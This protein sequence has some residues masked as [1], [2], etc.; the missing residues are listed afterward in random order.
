[1]YQEALNNGSSISLLYL[2]M[3]AI[4]PAQIGKSTFLKRLKGQMKWDL[5]A[6]V[7]THPQGSTGLTELEQVYV[8]YCKESPQAKVDRNYTETKQVCVQYSREMLAITANKWQT[9]KSDVEAEKLIINLTP[10][11]MKETRMEA[12]VTSK[13]NP[14]AQLA[15]TDKAKLK[16]H[17]RF[18]S[19]SDSDTNKGTAN[20]APSIIDYKMQNPQT[21]VQIPNE[22]SDMFLEYEKLRMKCR[23]NQQGSDEKIIDTIINVADVGGQPA[24]LEMLPSLTIGPAL[25]LVFMKLLQSL[26][27]PYPVQYK[28]KALEATVSKDY[29][30]TTE[31]IIFTALSSIAC[32]GHPDEEVEKYIH[33]DAATNT[34][35]TE[36]LALLIGTFADEVNDDSDLIQLNDNEKQLKQQLEETQFYKNGLVEFSDHPKAGNILFRVNNKN[37]G[38]DEVMMYR[39]LFEH[40]MANRFKKY[41][42][43]VKWFEFSICLKLLANMKKTFAIT[44]SDCLII[45]SQLKMSKKEVQ[46]ALQFLH[47]YTGL[48]MYFPENKKLKDII[49]CDPQVVFSSFQQSDYFPMQNVETLLRQGISQYLTLNLQ[50]VGPFYLKRH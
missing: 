13:I 43:P 7:E 42:I 49:I 46:V 23:I 27:K 16:A 26:K 10:L 4:G 19:D 32:F 39:Q 21:E 14:S 34:L 45:G 18:V 9:I 1:M 20:N 6:P 48:V 2:K 33:K 5:T 12:T 31:E 3:L 15:V 17:N 47:K 38:K 41:A 25:Y 24:F 11:L 22:I 29:S 50:R 44:F 35:K 8:Q 37:G 36:S 28:S 30:Y 40:L